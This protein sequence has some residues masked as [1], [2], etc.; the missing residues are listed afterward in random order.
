[1]QALGRDPDS[2]FHTRRKALGKVV[3][4]TTLQHDKVAPRDR[5]GRIGQEKR[6]PFD[7]QIPELAQLH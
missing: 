1:M 7:L 2:D 5:L 3:T 6:H 4:I